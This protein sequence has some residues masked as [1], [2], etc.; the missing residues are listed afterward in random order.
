MT[1]ADTLIAGAGR[2]RE[3]R[4]L[5]HGKHSIE[6]DGSRYAICR[7]ADRHTACLTVMNGNTIKPIA[8]FPNEDDARDFSI[9]LFGGVIEVNES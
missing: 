8:Y 6:L 9:K 2:S 5:W 4:V 3:V 7:Y 1:D